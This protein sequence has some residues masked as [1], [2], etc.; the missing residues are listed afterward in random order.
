MREHAQA[1]D[2]GRLG[3]ENDWSERDRLAAVAFGQGDFRRSKISLRADKYRHFA[4]Q[5]AVLRR[6]VGEDFLERARIGLERCDEE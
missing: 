4:G 2:R 5:V 6:V 3:A 1:V